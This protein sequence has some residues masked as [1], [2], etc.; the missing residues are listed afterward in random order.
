MTLITRLA[1][2]QPASQSD[3]RHCRPTTDRRTDQ[4]QAVCVCVAH[5]GKRAR[6]LAATHLVSLTQRPARIE[7]VPKCQRRTTGRQ[8]EAAT[9]WKGVYWTLPSNS[10]RKFLNTSTLLQIHVLIYDVA[11]VIPTIQNKTD[12]APDCTDS[13]NKHFCDV[14]IELLKYSSLH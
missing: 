14:I 9:G 7:T 3:S 10:S 4:Q 12:Y 6:A 5:D 13:R 1:S 2:S 8:L 11:S